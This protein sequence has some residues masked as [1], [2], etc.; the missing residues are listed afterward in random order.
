MPSIK[1]DTSLEPLFYPRSIAVIGASDTAGKLGY[2]VFRN[3][4]NHDFPGRLYPVN[5][6]VEYVQG[7]KSFRDISEIPDEIDEAVVIVPAKNTTRV[8][9]DCCNKG[10]KF[11]VNE[12]AGYSE[13]GSEGL[14]LEK[15][16]IEYLK[17][18]GTRM[19]GPNCSGLI[20]THN[21]MVQSLG[22]VG[23]LKK[24]NIG[25]VAQAGVYAA[26]LLWGFS[27]TQNFG[28]IA[29]VGNKL[30]L[31]ETDILEYL[32]EDRNIDVIAM[33]VEDIKAGRRF[34]DVARKVTERKPV[35][36]LKGG[37]TDIGRKTA[38]SHTASIAGKYEV[39]R[40][41]FKQSGI[42]QADSYRDVFNL[43][44]A[45]SKQPLPEGP[46][47][48]I[49]TYTGAMGVTGTDTCYENGIR[50][51]QLSETSVGQLKNLI[52]AYVTARNPVD[53][54][55]DQTPRQVADV[56]NACIRDEDVSSVVI[57]IQAE[58]TAEYADFIG[59]IEMHGKPLMVSIP[60]RNFA[61][62]PA[63][64]MEET[65][66]PVYDAPETAITILSKMYH[67][68]RQRRECTALV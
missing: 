46:G 10:V 14:V 23:P 4:L 17:S 12:A 31:N 53:L 28:I 61:I 11:I 15:E 55:F 49:I 35:I 33:Y 1:P 43:T 56:I 52:P 13:T 64:H 37:R 68:Y 5:P 16:I 3:L 40:A 65:G 62:E 30:D 42:I 63:I 6:G 20:N 7:V 8:I 57:V 18:S 38:A 25:L 19:V 60:A 39:Y 21:N 26:G 36:V 2:N 44:K 48:L 24:G 34:I 54:T 27:R 51:A 66:F 59:S 29:T 47:V 41:V 45:F 22:V 50:L 67:Y 9:R 58:M 32:G